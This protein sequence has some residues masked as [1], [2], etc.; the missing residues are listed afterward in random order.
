MGIFTDIIQRFKQDARGARILAEWLGDGG[1]PVSPELATTRAKLCVN[2]PGRHNRLDHRRIE[3][4]IAQFIK[5]QEEARG[6]IRLTTQYDQRLHSCLDT[7]SEKGCGCYLK[8][9]VWVPIQYQPDAKM[10]HYCWVTKEKRQYEAEPDKAV[11]KSVSIKRWAAF[12]D[13]IMATALA[14]KIASNGLSVEFNCAPIIAPIL[15]GHPSIRRVISDKDAISSIDLDDSYERNSERK[16]KSVLQLFVE[17]ATHRLKLFGIPVVNTNNLNPRI[18]ITEEEKKEMRRRCAHIP[19][20]WVAINHRSQSWP[21][22]SVDERCLASAAKM[23]NGS[24]IW[25]HP[26][27]VPNG[28]FSVRTDTFRELMALLSVVDLCITP[29]SGPMHAA[30][31]VGCPIIALEQ[32]IPIDLRLSNQADHITLSAPVDCVRCIEWKCPKDEKKPPCQVFDPSVI[33]D[34]AN[35]R[36]SG[37]GKVSAV[38]P[39]YKLHPR[40][41]RCLQAANECDELVVSLDGLDEMIVTGADIVVPSPGTRTGFG[42][43]CTRGA[44]HANGEF[45]LFLN[46]DCYL[47]P[48]A[49]EAMLREMNPDV[50]VVG[51]LLRYPDGKIQH[52]G[53]VRLGIEQGYGHID[54]G[55]TNPTVKSPIEMEFVT[56]A[57]VIVRRKAF[58]D[59]GG[60]D[61]DYDTYCEDSDLCLRLRKAGWK[62]MF[63]PHASAIHDESQTT[64]P[65][66]A[67]LWRKSQDVFMAK[68]KQYFQENGGNQLGK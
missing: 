49:V 10:P 64:S 19:R 55:K 36:L 15:R 40:L 34:T 14:D 29:D 66:K 8:L 5:E 9:K 1:E 59:V 51:C 35:K 2:C 50:A 61:E 17:A 3:P 11:E 6:K 67:Q 30:A 58:F 41:T 60:F 43:T 16:T 48:G 7:A 23:I 27:P 57:A 13:V 24:C 20:P 46:D 38:I 31:A 65:M 52:G 45:L 62:V 68:W 42:K 25:T 26:G 63:T 44:R 32:S 12:G 56:F 39:V 33:A 21:S 54:H 37:A 22:R 47:N 53:T 28:L 4:G 18:P